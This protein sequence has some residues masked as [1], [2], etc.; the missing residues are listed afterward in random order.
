MRYNNSISFCFVLNPTHPKIFPQHI[1]MHI[2]YIILYIL[3]AK[4]TTATLTEVLIPLNIP[5]HTMVQAAS[6]QQTM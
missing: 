2:I 3:Y 4:V 6:R 1:Y 5:R